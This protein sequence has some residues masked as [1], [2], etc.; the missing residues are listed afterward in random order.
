MKY[1]QF[2]PARAVNALSDWLVFNLEELGVEAPLVYSRLLLSLLHTTFNVEQAADIPY[3]KEFVAKTK[4]HHP[5]DIEELKKFAAV[6]LLLEALQQSSSSS[7]S[8]GG[9]E[10]NSGIVQLVNELYKKI[11][12]IEDSSASTASASGVAA[13]EQ[14]NV[15]LENKNLDH[16]LRSRFNDMKHSLETCTIEDVTKKYYSAFPAL[17]KELTGPS[18]NLQSS[19]DMQKRVVASSPNSNNLLWSNVFTKS[20]LQSQKSVPKTNSLKRKS[21]RKRAGK[22]RSLYVN[23]RKN[24]SSFDDGT[25]LWDMNF[26]GNWEMGQD[27][28]SDFV[29]QQEQ[30]SHHYHKRNRSISEGDFGKNFG[31]KARHRGTQQWIN[32]NNMQ[33]FY[34]KSSNTKEDVVAYHLPKQLLPMEK[35]VVNFQFNNNVV[36]AHKKPAEAPQPQPAP[37]QLDPMAQLKSKFD[38]IKALWDDGE[39]SL[40][41]FNVTNTRN[42]WEPLNEPSYYDQMSI[43]WASVPAH[44]LEYRD[45]GAPKQQ[46]DNY[47]FIKCGTNLQTSIWSNSDNGDSRTEDALQ[48]REIFDQAPQANRS[49]TEKRGSH[50]S[51]SNHSEH[52]MFTEVI[53]SKKG[54]SNN[55]LSHFS[56]TAT[57]SEAGKSDFDAKEDENLLTSDRTHFKPIAYPDGY[58]FDISNN[59][60]DVQFYRSESGSLFLDQDQ[61][62]ELRMDN[63]RDDFYG[64]SQLEA[65]EEMR[66]DIDQDLKF[67]VKFFVTTQNEKCCQTDEQE[68]DNA[69]TFYQ[70]DIGFDHFRTNW[71]YSEQVL[72]DT[73]I[74]FSGGYSFDTDDDSIMSSKCIWSNAEGMNNNNN[75][76]VGQNSEHHRLWEAC[77]TCQDTVSFPANRLLKDELHA[78]GEEILADLNYFQSLIIGNDWHDETNNNEQPPSKDDDYLLQ[79]DTLIDRN[80]V[81]QKVDK[82]VN[83]L[84]KPETTKTLAKALDTCNADWENVA[85]NDLLPFAYLF[86][87]QTGNNKKEK[88]RTTSHNEQQV[89]M[90]EVQ[91]SPPDKNRDHPVKP[92]SVNFLNLCNYIDAELWKGKEKSNIGQLKLLQLQNTVIRNS[93]LE[94]KR[95]H[96]A[97]KSLYNYRHMKLVGYDCS[98]VF[99]DE[100]LIAYGANIGNT[101]KLINAEHGMTFENITEKLLQGVEMDEHNF[102]SKYWATDASIIFKNNNLLLKQVDLTRP[103]TR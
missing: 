84:L 48:C 1:H 3:F 89:R 91:K 16:N 18:K 60:D 20:N 39:D 86:N 41:N 103:L 97:C 28:I 93:R 8:D 82:F 31:G 95:R 47:D 101:G 96:S 29:M 17:D 24:S 59:L 42:V 90:P 50:I 22:T 81:Y 76:N 88:R 63:M 67:V 2:V 36:N 11:R 25:S 27:M 32:N 44:T 65:A 61:Y 38:K 33:D 64:F 58:T 57:T 53:T 43:A 102:I 35:Q 49:L 54:S 15:P 37:P 19:N 72:A 21:K 74:D 9:P 92:S 83:D 45:C 7:A 46:L 62:M 70:S 99:D 55:L 71:R 94:R 26:E 100:T 87:C 40:E 69:Y 4:S 6:H 5:L 30:A 78:D 23:S 34:R 75:N 85:E 52:S 79:A 80:R 66:E 77:N 14:S 68:L 10:E 12:A 98:D 51:L 73:K 13:I 56:S